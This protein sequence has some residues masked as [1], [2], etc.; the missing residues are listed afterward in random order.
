MGDDRDRQVTE[1]NRDTETEL[2]LTLCAIGKSTV[3]TPSAPGPIADD[4][5]R[6]RVWF[7]NCKKNTSPKPFK[8]SGLSLAGQ[9]VALPALAGGTGLRSTAEAT[10]GEADSEGLSGWETPGQGLGDRP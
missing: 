7:N 10:G 9:T 1:S 4:G 6:F 8:V 3:Y 5:E 2:R